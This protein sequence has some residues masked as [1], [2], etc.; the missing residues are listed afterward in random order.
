M[1]STQWIFDLGTNEE[2]F[3][4][5]DLTLVD[6][7]SSANFDRR[8]ERTNGEEGKVGAGGDVQIFAF[9]QVGKGIAAC[10]KGRELELVGCGRHTLR[11]SG[12]RKDR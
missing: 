10:N 9:R 11:V 1:Q 3:L 8:P 6:W 12:A 2:A 4:T 5:A 7:V